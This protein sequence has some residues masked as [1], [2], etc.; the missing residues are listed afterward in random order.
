MAV[1]ASKMKKKMDRL[2]MEV[3]SKGHKFKL[4]RDRPG[5]HEAVRDY[6]EVEG[7]EVTQK[8]WIED[9]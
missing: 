4:N 8:W 7:K 6:V 1:I 9:P 3:K 5:Y 2:G